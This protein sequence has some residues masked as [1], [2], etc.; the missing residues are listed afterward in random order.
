MLTKGIEFYT[1]VHVKCLVMK[2]EMHSN[3]LSHF[4]HD[5]GFKPYAMWDNLTYTIP[6]H[7]KIV[8]RSEAIMIPWLKSFFRSGLNFI[9]LLLGNII[10]VYCYINICYI[11]ITCKLKC[12][13]KHQD[14]MIIIT[15]FHVVKLTNA[16]EWTF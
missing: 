7:F 4:P 14:N 8:I 9:N 12:V 10:F 1:F 3:R 16:F 2:K 11:Y 5:R 13:Q 15:K 6:T